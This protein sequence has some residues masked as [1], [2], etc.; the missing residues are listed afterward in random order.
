MYDIGIIGGGTA[1]M[2]AAIY[3]QRAGK[4]TVIIEGTNFGGQIVSSTNV[5]NYPGI[6]SV[7]GSE[8]SM[9]L[10]DQAMKLGAETVAEQA[11]SVQK[12]DGMFVIETSEKAYPCRSVILAT[13]VTH[14]HLGIEKEEKLVGAGV[15]YCATCDGAF[16]RG[17]DVAVIGGGNTA[18]QD[19]EFLSNYC[20][21]VYLVHR[22]DEFRG[23]KSLAERLKEK[24]NVEFVL[25]ATVKE[26]IGETMVEGLILNNKKTGEDFKIEVSGVFVAIGQIPQNDKFKDLIKLDEDGF[27]LASEDCLTSCPGVFAA[28]DC[29]TKEVR[30]L[31]TAAADGAVAGLAACKYLAGE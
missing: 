26:I 7:S 20:R 6:A 14:R 12:E 31:T 23:E 15:S 16:F 1:G 28:G 29:R 18:L 8:F 19:A 30:Q 17:R 11:D 10:L 21:K 5:E 2:T 25:S 4:R 27:I 24:E 22:R 13:G 3:G 9:N